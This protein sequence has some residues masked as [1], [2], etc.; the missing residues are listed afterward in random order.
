M[1]SVVTLWLLRF[2]DLVKAQAIDR[3]DRLYSRVDLITT[4]F[5]Y[6][7]RTGWRDDN[8]LYSMSWFKYL[9]K[10]SSVLKAAT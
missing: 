4:D 9:K 1:I 7:V 2:E 5:S 10:P 6:N 3:K 8:S